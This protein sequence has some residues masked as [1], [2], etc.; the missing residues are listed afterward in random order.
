MAFFISHNGKLFPFL[1]IL[2]DWINSN[3]LVVSCL[4]FW[5]ALSIHEFEFKIDHM[6]VSKVF[7]ISFNQLTTDFW[8]Q[9]LY[10]ENAELWH[11]KSPEDAINNLTTVWPDVIIIDSYWAKIAHNPCLDQVLK[12]K[13][14]TKIFCLTPDLNNPVL[15]DKRL[16]ISRFD[17]EVLNTINQLIDQS[18][19][20]I[21]LKQ[22]A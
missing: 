10:L 11:W 2:A 4:C 6:Q 3:L 5:N 16:C 15:I 22:I 9:H 1:N 7:I 13:G 18:Q 20:N 12:F 21:E 19:N 8:K 14:K 17:E